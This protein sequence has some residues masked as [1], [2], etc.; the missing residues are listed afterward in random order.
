MTFNFLR[1]GLT[2]NVEA[3]VQKQIILDSSGTKNKKNS[4]PK[5]ALT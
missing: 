2:V 1:D 3:E 4:W 5:A